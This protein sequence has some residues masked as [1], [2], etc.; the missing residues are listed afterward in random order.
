MNVQNMKAAIFDD[1]GDRAA[2]IS[3]TMTRYN[4][5]RLSVSAFKAFVRG[6]KGI[7]IGVGDLEILQA[8]KN[9]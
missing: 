3:F 6:E 1:D 9:P 8:P 4:L 2:R 5:L 7:A